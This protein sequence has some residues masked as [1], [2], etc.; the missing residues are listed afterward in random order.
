MHVWLNGE[1]QGV[2]FSD[3]AGVLARYRGARVEA[4]S[5]PDMVWLIK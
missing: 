5:R 2:V 3:L 4:P 1:Y